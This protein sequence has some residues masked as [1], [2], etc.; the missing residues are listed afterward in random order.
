VTN[1]T[2]L[3]DVE[4]ALEPYLSGPTRRAILKC[5]SRSEDGSTP[6]T[7]AAV[8]RELRRGVA[9]FA[10]GDD[11]ARCLAAL[12]RFAPQPQAVSLVELR[13]ERDISTAHTAVRSLCEALGFGRFAMTKIAT[14][15]MEIVRNAIRYAGGGTMRI[16]P[17]ESPK[18]GIEIVVQD[19]GPGIARLDDILSGQYRSRTGMGVGLRG[20]KA[21]ADVFEVDT[22]RSGTTVRL[23]KYLS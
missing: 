5:A 6:V 2:F 11:A 18:T 4:R 15:C 10:R 9:T 1:G 22:S 17:V 3:D 8:F 12:D 21:I 13:H 14:A 20:A 7:R 19:K 23:C 16:G